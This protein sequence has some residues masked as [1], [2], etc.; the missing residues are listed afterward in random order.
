MPLS[1]EQIRERLKAP[2]RRK[3]IADAQAH[4]RRLRFHSQPALSQRD[5]GRAATEFLD[6]VRLM[7]PEDKY[8]NFVALFRY[9]VKTV[10]LMEK[11]YTALEKVFDGRD[12]VRQYNFASPELAQD[13]EEYRNGKLGTRFWK[14]KGFEA[15]Q[16]AINSLVVVDLP[17]DQ[18]T[19][20]PEPYYYL[21]DI[22]EVLDYEMNGSRM[23]WVAF[24]QDGEEDTENIAVFDSEFYR[25]FSSKDGHYPDELIA[26]VPHTLG[27]CPAQWFWSTPISWDEPEC[28]K[29]PATT[30]LDSLDWLLYY[31][32]SKRNLDNYAAWPIY[33]GFAQDCDFEDQQAGMYCD[34]GFLRGPDH[35][36][37]IDVRTS[38]VRPCPVCSTK[39]LTGVGSFVEVPPPGPENDK[40]DLRNPVDIVTVDRASLDYNVEE[41]NRL[42]SEIYLAMTGGHNTGPINNQAINADQ[43]S[44][45]FEGRAQV[46]RS[47]AKNFEMAMQWA[48][49]TVC[50]LRYGATE[51]LGSSISLG[52]EW[53]LYSAD[54]I[55]EAYNAGREKGSPA[56]VLDM[57]QEQ[58]YAT[59]YRN[60]PE[61]QERTRILSNIEP[62][63]HMT[64][65]EA[66]EMYRAGE[67]G[68]EDY[69]VKVNFS[70][71]VLRFE[72]EQISL[73]EF[74]A[75]LSFDVKIR[76][77]TE[78]L[79]SYATSNQ[80]RNNNAGAAT[81]S[82][83]P[84]GQG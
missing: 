32:I 6:W 33:W 13:W 16:I 75:G 53:Y 45:Y 30:Q 42:Q 56:P 72:R 59:K 9:P 69:Y 19:P 35:Q 29:A 47:I 77:I 38:G 5:A 12:P 2:K 24:E 23:E 20:R 26:E 67:I 76:A 1:V 8:L 11:I 50:R 63:R 10:E 78:I 34:G 57:L 25:L 28:K 51:Y 3:K 49:D 52:T 14:T 22:G 4:E 73:Q 61:M 66:R 36:Y 7:L 41:I 17:P 39:R 15:M 31:S 37:L 46:L 81:E 84:A 44:A 65:S 80:E 83:L 79:Y 71:L 48:D 54:D 27:Y 60:N 74:G 58:Y 43:V 68:F 40:A 55:L 62:L 82:R 18:V 21:L 70:S 64:A